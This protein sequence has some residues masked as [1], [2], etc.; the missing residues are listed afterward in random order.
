[1]PCSLSAYSLQDKTKAQVLS[2]PGLQ[3]QNS[4]KIPRKFTAQTQRIRCGRV[5]MAFSD[6]PYSATSARMGL[7]GISLVVLPTGVRPGAS[8]PVATVRLEE[9]FLPKHHRCH[10][11]LG[12]FGRNVWWERCRGGRR[13]LNLLGAASNEG[14]GLLGKRMTVAMAFSQFHLSEL[15]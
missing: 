7:L 12:L 14:P 13:R 11:L 15:S 8:R 10:C 2:E 1:M 5:P 3:N 6:M 9:Y 4:I